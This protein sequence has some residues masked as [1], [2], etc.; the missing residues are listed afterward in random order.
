MPI[1]CLENLIPSTSIPHALGSCILPEIKLV[2]HTL[3]PTPKPSTSAFRTTDAPVEFMYCLSGGVQL[4]ATDNSGETVY[5]QIHEGSGAVLHLPLCNG[6]SIAK[7]NRP[8]QLVGLQLTPKNLHHLTQAT[9]CPLHPKL[10]NIF[11]G[12]NKPSIIQETP[13]PLPIRLTLQQILACPHNKDMS[14]LFL[15]YKKMELIYQQLALL[16]SNLLKTKCNKR[17]HMHRAHL[18]RKILME[19]MVNPPTLQ[20]LAAKV[21]MNKAQLTHTF[22]AAFGDT[23]FGILR[24]ERLKCARKMLEDGANSVTEVAYEC[25]FSSPSHLTKAFTEQYGVRPKQYQTTVLKQ[26]LGTPI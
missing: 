21:G 1:G 4:F 8:L 2:V 10:K 19:D 18:A 13:L 16:N 3:A 22:K 20:D 14:D 11:R 5:A 12:A 7:P 9:G 15:E 23:V 25:G 17:H 26:Q 6:Y 24:I